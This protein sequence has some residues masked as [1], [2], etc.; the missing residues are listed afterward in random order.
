[1]VSY[2]HGDADIAATVEAVDGALAVY[3]RALEDG[4]EHHLH[5]RP[6]KLVYRAYN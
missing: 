2:T 3:R 6:S 5:G 1:M 4:V